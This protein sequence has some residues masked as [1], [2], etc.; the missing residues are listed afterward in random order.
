VRSVCLMT[1]MLLISLVIASS[2]TLFMVYETFTV[3][4]TCG[5][6]GWQTG[7]SGAKF[8]DMLHR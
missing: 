4:D 8:F 2:A 3:L 6:K 5:G 7:G 1:L